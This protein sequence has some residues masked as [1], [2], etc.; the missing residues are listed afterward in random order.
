[1]FNSLAELMEEKKLTDK[2]SIPWNQICQ[3]EQL[4]ERF[5]KENLDQVNWKLISRHQKLSE[6]FIRKYRNRLFWDEIIKKQR[7]SETFIEKYADKKKWRSIAAEELSKKQQKMVEKEGA[8]FDAVE[9]WKLVSMKQ[10]LANSKGLSPA[11]IEKHQ[12]KLAWA[13]L[14]RYQYLP[15]P[16]IH[17]HAR[18]VDWTRVT[19]HQILSERFIEK[20]SNDVEWETISFHQ[21]LSERFINRHHAKMSFISAEEGRSEGFLYTHF[22]KLD[23]ASILEH[24]QLKEVKKYETLDVYVLTKNGQKKYILKFHD[25]IKNLEPVQKADEEELYEQLEEN[26]LLATVEEDFPELTI[27]GD[28]RF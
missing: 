9:Y 14:C 7:L 25:L 19:R 11:F 18:H 2:R 27:I 8:P 28:V 26:D 15:M 6:G 13:E 16:L 5:M 10:Q 21:S 3:E 23:A 20:Y 22:N 1:M 17:R 24:Q 4:S 12:D